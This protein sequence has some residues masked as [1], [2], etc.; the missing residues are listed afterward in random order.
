MHPGDLNGSVICCMFNGIIS[1]RQLPTYLSSD[2]DPLFRYHQWKANLRVL[3]VKEIKSIPYTPASHPFV[4]R[5]IGSVR[6]EL[7]D[8]TLFWNSL[9]LQKKFDGYQDYF[10]RCRS[11]M[12]LVAKTPDQKAK[13]MPK[14]IISITNYDWQAYS[15]GLFQLPVFA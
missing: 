1:K 3:D 6:H 2:N 9:D 8:Q 11:H 13:T 12:S 10:N 5:L 15:K 7:L 14:K 4:E